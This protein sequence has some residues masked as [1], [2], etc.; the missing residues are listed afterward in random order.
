[1]R[2]VSASRRSWK[3]TAGALLA[4]GV[5][6]SAALAGSTPVG[7]TPAP[8]AAEQ[9]P[10]PRPAVQSKDTPEKGYK[11]RQ[12]NVIAGPSEGAQ[13]LASSCTPVS[14]RDNPHRSFGDVSGH[15]WWDKGDCTSNQA[16]VYNC[17]W[18]YFTDGY[19]YKKAC[20]ATMTLYPTGGGG[21]RTTARATCA[22]SNNATWRN[23][24]DVDVIGQNDPPDYPMNQAD[25][26]CWVY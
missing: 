6:L 1:M 18:E 15:G 23:H 5:G 3:K 22:N 11:D 26:G 17:L 10:A 14:G 20:S 19:Y 13:T 24:V 9:D 4:A 2:N 12:G 25:V 8:A 21:N 16:N 7:A